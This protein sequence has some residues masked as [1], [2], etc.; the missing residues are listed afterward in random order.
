MFVPYFFGIPLTLMIESRCYEFIFM[1]NL[2][3]Y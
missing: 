1:K 3:V 2:C